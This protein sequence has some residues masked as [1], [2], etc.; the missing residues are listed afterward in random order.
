[1]NPVSNRSSAYTST[2]AA[3]DAAPHQQQQSESYSGDLAGMVSENK[4]YM[5]APMSA[6]NISHLFEW[7]A[8]S[9]HKVNFLAIR[10]NCVT[11]SD[12]PHLAEALKK[13]TRLQSFDIVAHE[14]GDAGAAALADALR[15]NGSLRELRIATADFDDNMAAKLAESLKT[16]SGLQKL[17][18]SFNAISEQGAASLARALE[19]NSHLQTLNLD[20]TNIG[21][22]GVKSLF[23]A[24]KTNSTLE[25]LD[26]SSTFI[27]DEG[28]KALHEALETNKTIFH[29]GMRGM[30]SH[31]LYG[32]IQAR[33]EENRQFAEIRKT[34]TPAHKGLESV[35]GSHLPSDIL[36]LILKQLVT[37]PAITPRD[38]YIA[39]T[40]L[41]RLGE[42]PKDTGGTE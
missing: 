23:D 6:E 33:L 16:N 15:F 25:T 9:G 22:R 35:L 18:L 3:T 10:N 21:Q 24:L 39:V 30:E 2:A 41:N 38:T 36:P 13:D 31:P 14:I 26:V 12:I 11:K 5:R 19:G 4:L 40:S 37:S 20:A 27:D 1:M 17:D 29:V 42:S 34:S 32:P 7:L 8:I 28:M